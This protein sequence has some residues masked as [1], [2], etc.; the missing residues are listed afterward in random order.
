MLID[1]P[2]EN[3]AEEIGQALTAIGAALARL[4]NAVIALWYPIK[5]ERWLASWQQRIGR[6]LSAPTVCLELWLYPRDARVALNGSGLLI[7][8]P[9]YRFAQS[10][11]G[12]QREL[13]ALLD[14]TGLGGCTIRTLLAG[15][16]AL[17]AGA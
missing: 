14:G 8:N 2:Y 9:P 16:D 12:W 15:K 11:N 4:A 13:R 7:V 5:D 10:A 1:P 3:P 17:H 6:E